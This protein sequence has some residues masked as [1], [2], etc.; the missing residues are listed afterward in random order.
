MNALSSCSD[1]TTP[2]ASTNEFGFRV[3]ITNSAKD[4]GLNPMLLIA[5]PQG[6]LLSR[7][8]S[9]DLISLSAWYIAIEL[10]VYAR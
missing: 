8:V 7:Y 2:L 4:D 3:D 1:K 9:S 5:L 6:V 10:F